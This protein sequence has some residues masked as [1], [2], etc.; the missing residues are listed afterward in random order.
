MDFPKQKSGLTP[1]KGDDRPWEKPEAKRRDYEPHRGEELRT[2]G[3]GTLVCSLLFC[4][5][6]VTALVALPLG[7]A[8]L[9]MASHDLREMHAGRMD[10]GGRADTRLGRGNALLG[11]FLS[12][13]FVLLSAFGFWFTRM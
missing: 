9:L 12:L 1:D 10:P 8:V 6:G 2:L 5:T 7:I 13:V 11:I 3:Y 4:V